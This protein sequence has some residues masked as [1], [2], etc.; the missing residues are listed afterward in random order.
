MDGQLALMQLDVR[1]SSM[2]LA[3]R[4]PGALV[5]AIQQASK[6]ILEENIRLRE[7]NAALE[8]ASVAL[9]QEVALLKEDCE[10]ASR[11][12]KKAVPKQ[13]ADEELFLHSRY[14]EVQDLSTKRLA[15]L[16]RH[17]DQ[18]FSG[19]RLEGWNKHTLLLVLEFLTGLQRR[20]PLAGASRHWPHLLALALFLKKRRGDRV[21]CLIDCTDAQDCLARMCVYELVWPNYVR[22]LFTR[23]LANLDIPVDG[24]SICY[25]HS[26]ENA[27]IQNRCGSVLNK[28]FDLL[29]NQIV[30]TQVALPEPPVKVRKALLHRQE[31]ENRKRC[32]SGSMKA[33]P[34]TGGSTA[35]TPRVTRAAASLSPPRTPEGEESRSSTGERTNSS[36]ALSPMRPCKL[37]AIFDDCA[38]VPPPPK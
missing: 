18:M 19:E 2:S 22:H 25:N 29:P 28:C 35:S 7:K 26:E 14:T 5:A 34:S 36:V 1:Q 32:R 9:K 23:Q 3:I 33:S 15:T 6:A 4:D 38:E 8:K 31:S 13:C 20:T 37:E 11:V 30:D 12:S 16:L 17:L 27:V 21:Q 10:A 24:L